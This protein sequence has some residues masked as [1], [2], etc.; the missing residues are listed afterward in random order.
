MQSK[1]MPLLADEGFSDYL[2]R[3]LNLLSLSAQKGKMSPVDRYKSKF[4]D[5]NQASRLI[6][7]KKMRSSPSSPEVPI[8]LQ[9]AE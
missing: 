6:C 7:A 5:R 8:S 2:E 9:N 1:L 3:D 4:G